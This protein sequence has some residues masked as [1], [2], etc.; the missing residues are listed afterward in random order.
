MGH[1]PVS[2]LVVLFSVQGVQ[3]PAGW[4]DMGVLSL[5]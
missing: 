3:L 4:G 1:L 2:L 5:R